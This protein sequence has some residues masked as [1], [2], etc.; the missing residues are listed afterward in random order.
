MRKRRV[1]VSFDFDND[2]NLKEFFVSQS[3]LEESP[4][5]ITDHSL[6]EAAPHWTWV[7]KTTNAIRRSETVVV[8]VGAKTYCA[9]GVLR[10]IAIARREEKRVIQ[11]A[12]YKNVFCRSVAG[13]GFKYEWSWANLKKLLDPSRP[14]SHHG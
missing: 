4:F 2:S 10:E 13:A 11:I 6:I 12:G 3:K 7:V 14:G 8:V 1:F 5:E 9:P